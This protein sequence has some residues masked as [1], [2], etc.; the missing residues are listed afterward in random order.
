[1][2]FF[3]F[4]YPNCAK[5]KEKFYSKLSNYSSK[6][7]VLGN[8][9]HSKGDTDKHSNQ[10]DRQEHILLLYSHEEIIIDLFDKTSQQYNTKK[11]KYLIGSSSSQCSKASQEGFSR[12]HKDNLIGKKPKINRNKSSYPEDKQKKITDT[13]AFIDQ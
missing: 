13:F 7:S 8:H 6:K 2:N 12:N 5:H 3:S 10:I 1:M 11:R 4:T 9:S